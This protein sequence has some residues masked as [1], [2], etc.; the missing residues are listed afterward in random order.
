MIAGK[1]ARLAGCGAALAGMLLGP[2]AI[3]SAAD[4]GGSSIAAVGSA[5]AAPKLLAAPGAV[6]PASSFLYVKTNQ[7]GFVR[8]VWR[9]IDGTR[10]GLVSQPDPSG[11]NG[12]LNIPLPGCVN[13]RAAVYHGPELMQDVTEPCTP[14]PAY[15]GDGSTATAVAALKRAA[16]TGSTE[17]VMK[18]LHEL[19]TETLLSPATEAAIFATAGKLPGVKVTSGSA[20]INGGQSMAISSASSQERLV[21]DSTS[22]QLLGTQAS[23]TLVSAVVTEL[24]SR[25]AS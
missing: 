14:N 15:L 23:S 21:F 22:K 24:G 12:M 1:V 18:Q 25:P 16:S 5:S 17:A 11:L 20:G 13:G 10:D 9:S 4:E 3:S 2:V 8:E 6:P 7:G 19:T